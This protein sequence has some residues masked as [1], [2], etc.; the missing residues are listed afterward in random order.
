VTLTEVIEHRQMESIFY[1]ADDPEVRRK[2]GVD[3]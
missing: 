2:L 1:L 3:Q